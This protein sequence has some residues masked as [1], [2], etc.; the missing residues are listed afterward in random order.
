MTAKGK[1]K[2][3]LTF[4]LID[5]ET[6]VTVRYDRR[7]FICC[8]SVV[9]SVILP[10]AIPSN[11]RNIHLMFIALLPLTMHLLFNYIY[12]LYIYMTELPCTE[13]NEEVG[14]F[15]TYC[16]RVLG[17]NLSRVRL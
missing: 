9:T 8:E 14:G 12:V 17:S 16:Q 11:Y 10:T 7:N 4:V 13:S 3:T 15:P 5:L 6:C 2:V 1:T